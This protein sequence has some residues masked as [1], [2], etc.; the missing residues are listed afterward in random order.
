[1][2]G[3]GQN[4]FVQ[5]ALAHLGQWLEDRPDFLFQLDYNIILLNQHPLAEHDL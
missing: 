1:M 2:R 4:S 5:H 3:V